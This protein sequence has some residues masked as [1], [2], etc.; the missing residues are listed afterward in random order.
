MMQLGE[1]VLALREA[2]GWTQGDLADRVRACG[3]QKVQYQHIQNLERSPAMSPRYI[4]ELA[5][6]FGKTVEELRN[7]RQGQPIFG[8]G[9]AKAVLR[10]EGG[11]YHVSYEMSGRERLLVEAY[12]RCDEKTQLALLQLAKAAVK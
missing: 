4:V 12:R 5:R 7:W 11:R 6:A 3:A 8:S 2:N 10:E 1:I 9:D